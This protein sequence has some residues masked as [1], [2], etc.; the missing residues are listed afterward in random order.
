MAFQ[1]RLTRKAEIE[2]ETAYQ[3]IKE[4]NPDYA[5][6]WFRDFMDTLA[7]LQEKP[8]RCA[9]AVENDV[10][11]E[12][13]RQLLYGKKQQSVYRI[14]FVIRDYKVYVLHVC[15]GRQAPLTPEDW[16]DEE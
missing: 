4:R 3:W 1:V 16:D 10:F 13:I 8:R 5:D 2:I 9:L 11:P 6:Q 14:L 15:H 7:T 12:E